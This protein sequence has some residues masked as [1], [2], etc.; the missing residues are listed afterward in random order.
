L[1]RAARSGGQDWPQAT[2][3]GGCPDGREALLN[4]LQRHCITIRINGPSLR[5]IYQRLLLLQI[6]TTRAGEHWL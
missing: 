5:G 4:K 6:H 1:S 2:A 3:A